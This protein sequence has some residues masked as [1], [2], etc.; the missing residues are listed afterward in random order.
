MEFFIPNGVITQLACIFE[1]RVGD[2]KIK[3]TVGPN[4]EQ[5]AIIVCCRVP[6][7]C[8]FHTMLAQDY[9]QL[10]CR[11]VIEKFVDCCLNFDDI[12]FD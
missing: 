4:S 5:A 8:Q 9:L 12:Y 11:K 3:C 7:G 1:V 6:M 2:R 10:E